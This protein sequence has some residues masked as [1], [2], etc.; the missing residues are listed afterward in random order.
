M[1][2]NYFNN[3]NFELSFNKKIILVGIIL[4]III[5]CIYLLIFYFSYTKHV[6][7]PVIPSCP[8][9]WIDESNNEKGSRC[10]NKNNIGV[11][12]NDIMNFTTSKWI[13]HN[14]KCNKYKWATQCK[15]SWDGITNKEQCEDL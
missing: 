1:F 4:S 14:G 7:P 8:D 11:C 15:V 9:Y 6:Y 5:F 10:V 12:D 13:G 2:N 3:Y